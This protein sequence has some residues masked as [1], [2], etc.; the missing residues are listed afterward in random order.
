MFAKDDAEHPIPS[1]WHATFREIVDAFVAGDY[2]LRDH[3]IVGVSPIDTS[4]AA[5]IADN[6]LAYGD[7]LA[8]L[9]PATWERSIYRWMGGYWQLLVDLTTTRERVSDLTLHAKLYRTGVTS[10][11]IESVHVP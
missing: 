4:T 6:V 3:V 8:P 5:S 10:L 1:E 2:A 9:N 7:T 11:E